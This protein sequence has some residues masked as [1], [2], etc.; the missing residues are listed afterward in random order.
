MKSQQQRHQQQRLVVGLGGCWR[1][2]EL[3]LRLVLAV[4]AATSSLHA[5]QQLLVLGT[6]PALVF[7]FL[8]NW[9]VALHI[10]ACVLTAL[11]ALRGV[12][13]AARG[14]PQST[15][16]ALDRAH[17]T[18][19][20][21]A[22]S[23]CLLVSVSFWSIVRLAGGPE[24][25][26]SPVMC[27]QH[28]LMHQQHT[29]PVVTLLVDSLLFAHTSAASL[30]SEAALACATVALYWATTFTCAWAWDDVPGVAQGS[31]FCST[32]QWPYPFLSKLPTAAKVCFVVAAIGFTVVTSFFAKAVRAVGVALGRPGNR[33]RHNHHFHN[34]QHQQQHQQQ[35]QQQRRP[36]KAGK[37]KRS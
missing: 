31:G 27:E 37:Q 30:A 23:I 16:G 17:E 13:A 10:A 35:N 33:L 9:S 24:A 32:I 34:H 36:N 15:P 4:C 22:T 8:T 18:V 14:V 11:V 2:A 20:A 7:R 5:L 26:L 21:L 6:P 25:V 3:L 29:V 1:V 19:H 28:L 12:A